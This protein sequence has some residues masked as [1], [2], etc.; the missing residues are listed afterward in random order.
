[1][2]SLSPSVNTACFRESLAGILVTDKMILYV[3]RVKSRQSIRLEHKAGLILREL[4]VRKG[5]S[6]SFLSMARNS[7]GKFF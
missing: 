1:M 3:R 4:A 5:D 6:S 7:A 2:K